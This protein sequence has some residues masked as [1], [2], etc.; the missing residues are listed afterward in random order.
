MSLAGLLSF[1]PIPLEDLLYEH[2]LTL[3]MATMVYSAHC[4]CLLCWRFHM[5]VEGVKFLQRGFSSGQLQAG[6]PQCNHRNI[7][8]GSLSWLAH[9]GWTE[10]KEDFLVHVQNPAVVLAGGFCI[11]E[12]WCVQTHPKKCC[13]FWKIEWR[14]G[15]ERGQEVKGP[16]AL[17]LGVSE[18]RTS[19]KVWSINLAKEGQPQGWSAV[20]HTLLLRG[21]VRLL[22]GCSEFMAFHKTMENA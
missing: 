16:E 20:R 19:I 8:T 18:D 7:L 15:K 3:A 2:K 10:V 11:Y 9:L 1:P 5:W 13:I 4:S 17:Y 6:N 21:A 14:H 12:L 22:K